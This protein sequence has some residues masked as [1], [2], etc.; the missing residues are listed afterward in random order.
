LLIKV[1]G[2]ISASITTAFLLGIWDAGKFGM[3]TQAHLTV[4][5]KK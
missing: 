1:P 3:F 5:M 2:F 4:V